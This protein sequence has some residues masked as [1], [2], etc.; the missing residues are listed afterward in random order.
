MI[1]F[2]IF[3]AIGAIWGWGFYQAVMHK[4]KFWVIFYAISLGIY[5]AKKAAGFG[6]IGEFIKGIV[7]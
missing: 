1:S 7:K 3:S 4:D 5:H 2:I 6:I